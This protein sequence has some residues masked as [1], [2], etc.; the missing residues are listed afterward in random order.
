[1][2]YSVTFSVSGKDYAVDPAAIA[3]SDLLSLAQ[4]AASGDKASLET[5]VTILARYPA[6]AYK[7]LP[8]MPP[9]PDGPLSMLDDDTLKRLGIDVA[10]IIAMAMLVCLRAEQEMRQ[11]GMEL[12]RSEVEQMMT[13]AV[14][15]MHTTKAANQSQWNADIAGAVAGIVGGAAGGFAGAASFRQMYKG[16][17]AATAGKRDQEKL[18]LEQEKLAKTR[19]ESDQEFNT[20]MYT[21]AAKKTKLDQDAANVKKTR[22]EVSKLR[23]KLL[24]DKNDQQQC[25]ENEAAKAK[26]A[27]VDARLK[28]AKEEERKTS[29]ALKDLDEQ[30]CEDG[31]D[32]DFYRA[33][34]ESQR[35]AQRDEIDQLEAER[36]TLID[37]ETIDHPVAVAKCLERESDA[38]ADEIAAKQEEKTTLESKAADVDARQARLDAEASDTHKRLKSG[39]KSAESANERIL[40]ER[41]ALSAE[42]EKFRQELDDK[43]TE[44]ADLKAKKVKI[45]AKLDGLVPAAAIKAQRDDLAATVKVRAQKVDALKNKADQLQSEVDRCKVDL[46]AADREVEQYKNGPPAL[47]AAATAKQRELATRMQDKDKELSMAQADRRSEAKALQTESQELESKELEFSE[48]EKLDAT[49]SRAKQQESE[50]EVARNKVNREKSDLVV[51]QKSESEKLSAQQKQLDEDFSV[52][53]EKAD[54]NRIAVEKAAAYRTGFDAIGKMMSGSLEVGKAFYTLDAADGRAD[55]QFVGREFEI[56]QIAQGIYNT[57]ADNMYSGVSESRQTLNGLLLDNAKLNQK[58]AERM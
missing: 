44:I 31:V 20:A 23:E 19:A 3:P 30:G 42:K 14:E 37:Q 27:D 9:V 39:D 17:K 4:L 6:S 8:H 56:L 25:D 38:V 58:I 26:L 41:A 47:L 2:T 5:F 32:P 15:E 13:K 28:A 50:L 10:S 1:M 54:A 21:I 40:N 51:K 7:S 48:Y 49:Q 16:D 46:D 29:Q 11:M 35:H 53:N 33:H 52:A 55:A 24:T 22:E 36:S 57:F 12:S 43:N 18:R 45:D 34:L